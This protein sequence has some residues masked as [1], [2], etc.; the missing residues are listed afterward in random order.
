M[1]CVYSHNSVKVTRLPRTF[2]NSKYAYTD[3]VQACALNTVRPRR[4]KIVFM[5]ALVFFKYYIKQLP[6][7]SKPHRKLWDPEAHGAL[8]PMV[9]LKMKVCKSWVVLCI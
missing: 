9:K 3:Q 5:R 8:G 2:M 4:P 7:C 6:N 1:S